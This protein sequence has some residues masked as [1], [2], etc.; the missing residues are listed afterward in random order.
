[1]RYTLVSHNTFN[2][3]TL[4]QPHGNTNTHTH[5]HSHIYTH[6]HLLAEQ[7]TPNLTDSVSKRDKIMRTQTVKN[8]LGNEIFQD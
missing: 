8:H 4:S 1:M 5:S 6:D 2:T 7:L 3:H